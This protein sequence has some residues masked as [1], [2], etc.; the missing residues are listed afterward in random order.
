MNIVSLFLAAWMSM[1]GNTPSLGMILELDGKATLQRAGAQ[2]PARLAETLRTGDRIQVETGSL[3]LMFCPTSE[4][5]IVRAGTT[6]ELQAN[7][8]RVAAGSQPARTPAQCILPQVA[9]GQE[10]MERVGGLRA[11]G[12]PPI[13]LFTGGPVTSSRPVFEWAAVTGSPTYRLVLKNA[14]DDTIWQ[15]ETT[16]T[17]LAYPNTM[18][19]LEPATYLWEL[20]AFLAG[21]VIAEQTANFQVK[22]A[23]RLSVSGRSDMAAMLMDATALENLGYYAEA[24]GYFREIKKANPSDDRMTRHLVWLYWNAGLIAASNAQRDSLPK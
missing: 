6:L 7:A 17:K 18:A 12:T 2:S 22:P 9:L 16:A 3:T 8:L 4:R 19:A 5:V 1:Q 24:A 13:S 20:R 23:G 11:R 21:K 10:S 14:S 15:S